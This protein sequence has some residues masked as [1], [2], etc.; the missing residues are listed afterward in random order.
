ML[1]GWAVSMRNL[2]TTFYPP[3]MLVRRES[4]PPV[5][6]KVPRMPPSRPEHR[7]AHDVR[8][9]KGS[10]SRFAL[11]L[12]LT[13]TPGPH[14]GCASSAPQSWRRRPSQNS[15][16]L[17]WSALFPG[18]QKYPRTSALLLPRVVCHGDS[19]GSAGRRALGHPAEIRQSQWVFQAL[20]GSVG[21]GAARGSCEP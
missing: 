16:G 1:G 21:L 5:F 6:K 10:T 17:A 12:T 9:Q 3:A 8:G 18:N 15:G 4:L 13:H 20:G 2:T 11:T 19:T 14:V 7:T